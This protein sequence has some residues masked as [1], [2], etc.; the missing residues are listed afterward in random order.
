MLKYSLPLLSFLLFCCNTKV[1]SVK[2]TE[3]PTP[4]NVVFILADDIGAEWIG[5]YGCT[6]QQTPNIDH[7][8]NQGYVFDNFSSLPLCAPSRQTILTGTHQF[9]RHKYGNV[10]PNGSP[11]FLQILNNEGFKI[12]FY[13]KWDGFDRNID[14]ADF[15]IDDYAVF[16]Q[17][18]RR[19]WQPEIKENN[20]IKTYDKTDYGPDIYNAKLL[21]FISANKNQKFFAYYAMALGHWPFVPTPDSKN[22][23]ETNWQTNFTDMVNYA[24]KLIGKVTKHLES[25]GIADE[26]LVIFTTDN[27]TYP[28]LTAKLANDS[29]A[30]GGK[31]YPILSGQHV[32][33]IASYGKHFKHKRINHLADFTDIFPTLMDVAQVKTLPENYPKLDGESLLPFLLENKPRKKEYTLSYFGANNFRDDMRAL[34]I[35]DKNWKLY[36]DGRLVNL[37]NDPSEY[38]FTLGF[39]ENNTQ[40]EARN[41]LQNQLDRYKTDANFNYVEHLI[42]TENGKII[43]C[44]N[45]HLVSLSNTTEFT[46][47]FTPFVT[48]NTNYKLE[49]QHF[50]GEGGVEV[51]NVKLL[52]N[53]TVI[54]SDN[55]KSHSQTEYKNTYQFLVT[56][57]HS[58]YNLNCNQALDTTAQYALKFTV[59]QTQKG[60]SQGIVRF[61]EE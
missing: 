57:A 14:L 19:F 16:N 49:I 30:K 45:P 23:N 33:F 56:K 42:A 46:I 18:N 8:A 1:S 5:A 38:K 20:R 43:A 28:E 4:K 52:K 50:K 3:I 53:N 21:D 59:T 7:L 29:I 27:G 22:K 26:T 13:G 61:F 55:H 25:L 47:D 51:S 48:Q 11:T 17:G 37:N 39:N 34:H 58:V 24:D 41:K 6:S 9:R 60:D 32:P 40:K 54:A 35:R 2:H 15:K 31:S 10:M 44:W 12:G 36:S